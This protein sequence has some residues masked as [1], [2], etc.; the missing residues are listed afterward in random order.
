MFQRNILI[1]LERLSKLISTLFK[2]PLNKLDYYLWDKLEDNTFFMIHASKQE[3]KVSY[4][5]LGKNHE[6]HIRYANRRR[7]Q[8]ILGFK[9]EEATM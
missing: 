7:E 4:L 3:I 9:T 1:V 2:I 5:T 8:K 6:L